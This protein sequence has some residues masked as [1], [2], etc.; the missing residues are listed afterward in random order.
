MEAQGELA[1]VGFDC[2]FCKSDK[3]VHAYRGCGVPPQLNGGNALPMFDTRGNPMPNPISTWDSHAY[4]DKW[5]QDNKDDPMARFDPIVAGD[6]YMHAPQFWIWDFAG[7]LWPWCP[8]WFARF[9]SGPDTIFADRM[10]QYAGLAKRRL[11]E[12]ATRRPPSQAEVAG[13]NLVLALL[14]RIKNEAQ[15]RQLAELKEK[16]EER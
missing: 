3:E 11:L 8:A 15:E 4:L 16:R 14:D 1:R 7:E 6:V 10:I 13:T 5:E 12:W 2:A 9:A